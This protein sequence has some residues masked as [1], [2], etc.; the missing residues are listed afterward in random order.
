MTGGMFFSLI[1]TVML[2]PHVSRRAGLVLGVIY[3]ALSVACAVWER[4]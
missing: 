4:A 1:A 2:A 3:L